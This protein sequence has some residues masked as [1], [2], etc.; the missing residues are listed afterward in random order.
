MDQ[1]ILFLENAYRLLNENGRF[2]IVL[3]NSI[4][5]TEP[6]QPVMEWLIE[7]LRIVAIFDLPEKVFAETNVNPT[8]IVAYKPKDAELSLLKRQN[9]SVFV[10]TIKKVGYEVI[11]QKRNLVFQTIYKIDP[12]S[13]DIVVDDNGSLVVDEDFTKIISDFREW[14]WSQEDTL[15][16]LFLK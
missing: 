5:A 6:W 8:L 14:I 3:S 1:G 2:G 4:V 16:N 11:T 7:K 12:V 9:Y 10:R 13:F 15:Q